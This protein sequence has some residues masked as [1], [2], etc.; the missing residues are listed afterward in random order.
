[1]AERCEDLA[2]EVRDRG[3]AA[4]AGHRHDGLRLA[5]MDLR[6]ASASAPPRVV[7]LREGDVGPAGPRACSARD[8]RDGAVRHRLGGEARAVRLGAG[9]ATNTK[10][11]S[12]LRL[13]VATP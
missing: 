3:L 10:P 13:S 12:T 1:M 2:G 5:R 8:D 6:A 7:D 9:E 4:G 11:G